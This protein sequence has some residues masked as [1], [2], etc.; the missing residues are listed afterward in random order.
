MTI[1]GIDLLGVAKSMY[2]Q[3]QDDD[4]M[5][6]AAA[7]AYHILFSVVPLL[8]FVTALSGFIS[9]AIGQDD[10][11]TDVTTWLFER[12]PAE[13]AVAV[14][15]PIREVLTQQAGG[16]LSI[17]AVLALW[18]GKNAVAAMMKGL[19]TAFDVEE[20]RSWPVR[21][22]IAIGLT[23]ALGFALIASSL[24]FIVGLTAWEQ[25]T[26]WLGISGGWVTAL[27]LVRWPVILVFLVVGI[28]ILYWAGP[29]VDA[30]FRWLTPGAVLAVVLW[31]ISTLGLGLYFRY[32]G[33]YVAAY[34]VLG[35]VLAF[36]F[37]LYLV[38]LLI[39]LGGELNAILPR[40][41]ESDAS[42]EATA[43]A[44]TQATRRQTAAGA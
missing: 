5:D 29:N 25:V 17:G 23:A 27:S 43:R 42:G 44:G 33:S 6:E 12:L 10:V 30:S 40:R 7:V 19:N 8:V 36:I 1:R 37:W 24:A 28:G 32:A 15:D 18:S 21:N 13:T 16:L 41:A 38:S 31:G 26:D 34:G 14:Q 9:N 11:V 39:L 4:L 20:T 3:V 22:G 35:G 2:R